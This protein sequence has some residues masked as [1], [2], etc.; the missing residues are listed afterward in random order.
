MPKCDFNK[1]ALQEQA[2]SVANNTTEIG[3]LQDT[4]DLNLQCFNTGYSNCFQYISSQCFISIFPD[5]FSK[6]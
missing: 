2:T 6:T 4:V 1:V 3:W 5:V